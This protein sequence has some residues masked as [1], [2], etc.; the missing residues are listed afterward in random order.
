[1]KKTL[2]L[3][4]P[5]LLLSCGPYLLHSN[6]VPRVLEVDPRD[7]LLPG[8]AVQVS[9]SLA[10]DRVSVD[11]ALSL[12]GPE[13]QIAVRLDWRSDRELLLSPLERE[14]SAGP[15]YRLEISTLARSEEGVPL[16]HAELFRFSSSQD[17]EAPEVVAVTPDPETQI[18]SDGGFDIEIRF[19]EPMDRDS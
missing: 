3:L 16:R 17:T 13:G 1:M 12:E 18:F 8:E 4:I 19:S 5:T 7:L 10:M 2:F 9:F 11:S 15:E 6:K 14:L